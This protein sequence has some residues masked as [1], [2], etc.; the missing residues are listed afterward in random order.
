MKIQHAS[1]PT[2]GTLGNK[3]N[4]LD[5]IYANEKGMHEDVTCESPL[6][7]SDHAVLLIN[8]RRYTEITNCTK[9]KFY[10][11]QYD[12]SGMSAKLEQCRPNWEEML[13]SGSVDSQ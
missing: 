2:R 9:L 6:G 8:Y 13:G 7:K 10:Y 1:I 12:Y 11:N 4:I 5:M 3:S